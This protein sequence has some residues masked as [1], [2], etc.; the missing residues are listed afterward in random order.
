MLDVIFETIP[1]DSDDEYVSGTAPFGVTVTR[2]TNS[3]G[4]EGYSI[5]LPHQSGAWEIVP[6]KWVGDERPCTK[7]E[8]FMLLTAFQK[9]LTAALHAL[10][11]A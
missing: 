3:E 8:A 6:A 7:E 5:S 4:I 2:Y 9:E 1:W 10:L 11:K